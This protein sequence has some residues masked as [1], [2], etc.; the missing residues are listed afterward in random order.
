[1]FSSPAPY[2]DLIFQDATTQL[3]VIEPE[4]R[5]YGN[6]LGGDFLRARRI[7]DCHAGA[8]TLLMSAMFTLLP[9]LLVL[10]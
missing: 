8:A 1:M 9:T 6:Y 10:I 7:V 4:Q 5:N 2:S 3:K